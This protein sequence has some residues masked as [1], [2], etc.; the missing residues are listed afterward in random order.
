MDRKI[1]VWLSRG[2]NGIR[3][4]TLVVGEVGMVLVSF[5]VKWGRELYDFLSFFLMLR[6]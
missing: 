6:F 2:G 5:F 3:G 1:L 4:R